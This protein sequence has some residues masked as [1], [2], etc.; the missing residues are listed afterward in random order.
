MTRD[1]KT[2]AGWTALAPSRCTAAGF[3]LPAARPFSTLPRPWG[4]SGDDERGGR[5][6]AGGLPGG[7]LLLRAFGRAAAP[8]SMP[9]V[10]RAARPHDGR[11]AAAARRRAPSASSTISASPSPSIPSKDAIDRILPFDV[12]PRVLSGGGMAA[13]RSRRHPAGH[14]AQPLPPRHLSRAARSCRTASSRASSCSATRNYRPEMRGVDL[15]HRTYVHICG[16][17]IVRDDD[18]T[19]PGA[20]GQC[21]AR[22]PGVSYVVENR[23][24]MLRAFPDL[25]DGIGLRPVDDYGAAGCIAAMQRDRARRRE[26]SAGR[27]AV[28]RHLQLGLFRARL[29]RPRDGRAAGRGPRPA[30]RGRPRLHADDRRARA[31]RRD[32]SPDRR[33]FPRS[34]RPSGPTAC[35]ACPG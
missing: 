35:S 11:R 6:L 16:T 21:A 13:Y 33:R 9:A 15:P 19:L 8:A 24:M 22:P 3:S 2:G 4:M 10:A 26:R 27:A 30:G 28:A 1:H 23:H 12:I 34:A 18:G 20:G 31:G 5:R 32:L 14:R 7:R 29:P 25:L 17:D